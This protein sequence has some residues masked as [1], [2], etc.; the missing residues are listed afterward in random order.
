MPR[1]ELPWGL[2]GAF[3]YTD[4]SIRDGR[5]LFGNVNRVSDAFAIGAIIPP[6]PPY[7]GT[8]GGPGPLS[9]ILQPAQ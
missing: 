5:T 1:K 8:F 3:N 6:L 2:E 9:A 7:A 4:L